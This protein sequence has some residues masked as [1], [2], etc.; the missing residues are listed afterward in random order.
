MQSPN[1]YSFSRR[2]HCKNLESNSNPYFDNFFGLDY[3][4]IL[5]F[6]RMHILEGCNPL[7]QTQTFFKALFS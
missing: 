1:I 2:W 5:N 7:L 3:Q 6:F 4:I